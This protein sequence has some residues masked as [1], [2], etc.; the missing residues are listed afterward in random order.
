MFFLPTEIQSHIYSFDPTY[1][2]C[3][4]NVEC[5][6][7]RFLIYDRSNFLNT[8]L[9]GHHTQ[10]ES[11]LVIYDK[12]FYFKQDDLLRSGR[13][14][15]SYYI[16]KGDSLKEKLQTFQLLEENLRFP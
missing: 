4:K 6:L 9:G 7:S 16:S 5:Q 12:K 2:L 13:Y 11:F 14:L 3:F 15:S 10:G 8:N 1:R